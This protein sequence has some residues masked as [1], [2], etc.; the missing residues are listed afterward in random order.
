MIGEDHQTLNQLLDRLDDLAHDEP[1][2]LPP[3]ALAERVAQLCALRSRVDA[4]LTATVGVWDAQMVWRDDGATS[5]A[6][7]LR[8]HGDV[9]AAGTLVKRAR[10]LRQFAPGT[11]AA[12][13]DGSL[14]HEKAM[15]IVAPVTHDLAPAFAKSEAAIVGAAKAVTLDDIQRLVASW[16][17]IA[18][19]DLDVDVW[20]RQLRKRYLRVWDNPDGTLEGN[21]LLDSVAGATFRGQLA[22]VERR[23]FRDDVREARARAGLPDADPAADGDADGLALPRTP[24]QRRADALCELAHAGARVDVTVDDGH[25][26]APTAELVITMSDDHLAA[27]VDHDHACG[28]AEGTCT[29]AVADHQDN[30]VPAALVV[31]MA[32]DSVV[33]RMVLD[34][35]GV[36]LNMGRAVRRATPA[37][38]RALRQRD[39]GCAFPGCGRPASW[40]DA[41]HIVWWILFGPTDLDNLVL[42]CRKHHGYMHLKR[43]WTCVIDAD[44]RRPEFYDPDGQHVPHPT[45]LPPRNTGPP[46]PDPPLDRARP[47]QLRQVA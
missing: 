6:A 10:Q 5:G 38:L 22:G 3:A 21:F 24:A 31:L 11:L 2:E 44:T 18:E 9:P 30:P 14:S 1:A 25:L 34:K 23:L 29:G 32:C 7:W 19:N 17:A 15:A 36:A 45:G 4:V 40:C 13:V 37:Q 27:L 41:H 42:L 43:P 16:R 46:G 35:N 26:P 39:G 12:L 20:E 33:R 47:Q 8:T 28:C